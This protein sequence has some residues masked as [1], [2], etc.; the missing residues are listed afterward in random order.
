MPLP[1]PA[2]FN[3]WTTTNP[4]ARI[5]PTASKK[6]SGWA[7]DE[8]P[9][10]EFMNFLFFNIDDW[11]KYLD[12][13]VALVRSSA[14]FTVNVDPQLGDFTTLQDAIDS[15][16]VVAGSK[17]LV[18]SDLTITEAVQLSKQDIEIEFRPGSKIILDAGVTTGIRGLEI[19]S[20]ADRVRLKH[21]RFQGFVNPGDVCLWLDVGA[22]NVF[23]FNP[24]FD[25][26]QAQNFEDNSNSTYV[27]IGSQQL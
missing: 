14:Q 3:E 2:N 10:F 19:I 4:T 9:S 27:S 23:L 12:S 25:A 7:A 24:V 6:E 26:G 8:R 16:D 13:Q 21:V 15:V 17:I 11:L 18:T 1:R 20:T 22:D 5:E